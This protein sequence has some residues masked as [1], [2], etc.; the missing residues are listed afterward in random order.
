ME[1]FLGVDSKSKAIFYMGAIVAIFVSLY[2][3]IF[4]NYKVVMETDQA[5]LKVI[6]VLLNGE[7]LIETGLNSKNLF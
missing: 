1:Q 2:W 4:L 3:K 6:H 7:F 5:T